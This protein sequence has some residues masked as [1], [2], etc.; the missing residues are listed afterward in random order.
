V[1]AVLAATLAS[2]ASKDEVTSKLGV[3]DALPLY[4]Q[5]GSLDLLVDEIN[6]IVMYTCACCGACLIFFFIS[7]SFL[8]GPRLCSCNPEHAELPPRTV[9]IA[10]S[11]LPHFHVSAWQRLG[12]TGQFFERI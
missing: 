1:R 2:A 12:H 6:M 8:F 5:Q 7:S 4:L 3:C 10:V 9:D 11:G